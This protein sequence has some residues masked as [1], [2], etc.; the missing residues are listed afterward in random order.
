MHPIINL[1]TALLLLVSPFSTSLNSYD[2]YI[3]LA[4]LEFP[5]QEDFTLSFAGAGTLDLNVRLLWPSTDA[6]IPVGWSRDTD[7]DDRFLQ[8][9]D[10]NFLGPVNGG[11]ENHTHPNDPHTPIGET[12]LHDSNSGGRGLG[13]SD[14][15]R[16]S[17]VSP[18]GL[19]AF[20]HSTSSRDSPN[21]TIVYDANTIDVN[22]NK[23]IPPS[24][25]VI[26]IKP[27]D[28]LQSFPDGAVAFLNGVT[29]PTG[30]NKLDGNN[31]TPDLTD[32][33]FLFGAETGQDG[34]TFEGSQTHE[35]I[36]LNVHRHDDNPNTHGTFRAGFTTATVF[37]LSLIVVMSR[38]FD[39]HNITLDVNTN[40]A[41]DVNTVIINDGNSSPDFIELLGV[42]N[43]SGGSLSSFDEI[44]LPF[45]GFPAQIPVG[46]VQVTGDAVDRQIKITVNTSDINNLDGNT[47]DSHTTEPD[48]HKHN[49]GHAH[50][51]NTQVTVSISAGNS[52]APTVPVVSR[53]FSH[54][55]TWTIGLTTPTL[56]G[57][58]VVLDAVD[59]RYKFRSIILIRKLPPTDTCTYSGSG[60]FIVSCTD[61]CLISSDL[62]L[63]GND[64][65]LVNGGIFGINAVLRRIASIELPEDPNICEVQVYVLES[66]GV[67]FE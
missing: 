17:G 11:D 67:E 15:S 29:I 64:L 49:I 40:G 43:T 58:T 9:R 31:S 16:I 1:L 36:D 26:I 24:Y 32:G 35:H 41:T 22:V 51:V 7:F 39:H 12:H 6:S 33:R 23:A 45:V 3:P 30:F 5:Q 46:W 4:T 25:R 34:N 10:T 13:A 21:A 56:Q 47:F 59:Q 55:H 50:D 65:I 2:P 53:L 8:V 14:S 19:P 42:Q 60:D 62:D 18:F 20:S 63:G 37:S 27:D 54:T 44:V 48:R 28:G 52:S 66:G 57:A 38:N 61:N